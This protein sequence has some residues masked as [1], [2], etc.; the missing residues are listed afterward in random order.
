MG[1]TARRCCCPFRELAIEMSWASGL[2]IMSKTGKSNMGL[3]I[4]TQE[5]GLIVETKRKISC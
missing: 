2:Y 4:H 3:K 5:G 1:L